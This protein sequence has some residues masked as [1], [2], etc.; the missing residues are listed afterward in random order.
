RNMQ[1]Q[2]SASGYRKH[3]FVS[4]KTYSA[5]YANEDGIK[6]VHSPIY[7]EIREQQNKPKMKIYQKLNP[8]SNKSSSV[9]PK[10]KKRNAPPPPENV[11]YDK[12]NGGGEVLNEVQQVHRQHDHTLQSLNLEMEN[13]LMPEENSPPQSCA[14]DDYNGLVWDDYYSSPVTS[15]SAT[16][17]ASFH[18]LPAMLTAGY[19]QQQ[20][21][22]Q[23]QDCPFA[24]SPSSPKTMNEYTFSPQ[25]DF[26]QQQW[27]CGTLP[28]PPPS[29]MRASLSQ[30]R[31]APL[32]PENCL[33]NSDGGVVPYDDCRRHDNNIYEDL[34]ANSHSYLPK[35][36]PCD[37]IYRNGQAEVVNGNELR[38]GDILDSPNNRT[39]EKGELENGNCNRHIND[40]WLSFHSSDSECETCTDSDDDSQAG[41]HSLAK[42]LDIT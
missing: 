16:S 6:S 24:P 13:M 38:N 22:Q 27:R 39:N 30:R 17:T 3:N 7:E 25:G 36:M 8:F 41:D 23:Q 9:V 42:I 20:L 32:P 10:R 40:Q 31:Q 28:Q 5:V 11:D 35:H 4:G 33:F 18:W 2:E 37:L 26:F 12:M 15:P 14:A 19:T 1:D 29:M 21:I 34:D